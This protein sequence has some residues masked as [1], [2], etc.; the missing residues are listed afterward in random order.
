MNWPKDRI[1]RFEVA[2]LVGA[3][4]LQVSLG[5]PILVKAEETNPIEIS[6]NEF[7]EKMIP[8][9]IKRKLPNKE[10]MVID[11]KKGIDNWLVDNK[12]EI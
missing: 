3:R 5:A 8:I 10:E 7:K 1:T 2:R 9:T 12:G 6:K 11:V 4:A